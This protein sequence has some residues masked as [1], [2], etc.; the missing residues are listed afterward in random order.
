MD[1][2]KLPF[3]TIAS[4]GMPFNYF[5]S[6]KNDYPDFTKWL[7]SNLTNT[8][9]AAFLVIKNDSVVYERYFSPYK[10][11]TLLPSFSVIKS[12]VATLVGIAHD[13]GRIASL[14]AP[15]TNYLPE[16]VKKDV[17]FGNITIQNLLD[18][19]SGI[20]WN[21]GSYNLK[22]DAIKMGFRPNILKYAL[23]VKIATTPENDDEYKSINTLLLGIILERVYHQKLAVLFE[24]K[25][26]KPMG[27]ESHAT[28]NTDKHGQAITFGGLNA[29]ARD[30]AKLGRLYLNNGLWN[31][32][33][34]LSKKWITATV[35]PDSMFKYDG[36]RNQWWGDEDYNFVKDSAEAL[37]IKN[38]SPNIATISSKQPKNGSKYFIVTTQ[39]SRYYAEGILGEFV[40]VEPNK[41]LVVVRLGYNWRHPKYNL[42]RL[43]LE[44]QERF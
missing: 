3:Q 25:I 43:L 30:Y 40:C 4:S 27:M 21:E 24:Q 7:D 42:E 35:S 36:Y 17:R 18:M 28:L 31:G 39:S 23:K 44:T 16:L 12:F 2:E 15:I 29:I 1:H 9:T 22:D 33:Q 19:R 38:K 41:N 32:K 11:S 20:T 8:Q 10:R 14:Y 37:Q 26:W 6:K 13:D 34:L 5:E